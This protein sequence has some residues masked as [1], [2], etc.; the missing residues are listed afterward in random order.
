MVGLTNDGDIV[1]LFNEQTMFLLFLNDG[2][3]SSSNI[4]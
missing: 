4:M 3:N 1:S 2:I